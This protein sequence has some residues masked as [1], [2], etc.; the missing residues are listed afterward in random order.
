MT[1]SAPS[2]PIFSSVN[3]GDESDEDIHDFSAS[4][5]LFEDAS[6][7]PDIDT[8]DHS[9]LSPAT[10]INPLARRI[11]ME[12]DFDTD[13][14]DYEGNDLFSTRKLPLGVPLDDDTEEEEVT[15]SEDESTP[16]GRESQHSLPDPEELKLAV[17]AT[18]GGGSSFLCSYSTRKRI[19]YPALLI[20]FAF[21][22]VIFFVHAATRPTPTAEA[23]SKPIFDN[24]ED[25][26]VTNSNDTP[27]PEFPFGDM[28]MIESR[29]TYL[30]DYLIQHGITSAE[31]LRD[32]ETNANTI[33]TPQAQA[34]RWLA[35]EDNQFPD[36]PSPGQGPSTPEGYNLVSRYAMVVLYFTT[37]GKN[38]K[39]NLNFLDPNKNTCDWY[40][41]FAP[42]KGE[43]GV[44]CNPYTREIIG[45]SM[46]SNNVRGTIPSELSH[47]TSLEY[48]ESI[49]NPLS[50]SIPDGWQRLTALKTVAIAFNKLT[51]TLPSWMPQSW[52]DMEFLYLSNNALTG[53][54]PEEFSGFEKLSVLALDDNILT[55]NT[56][57]LWNA[58][59]A[60]EFAYLEDNAFTGTLPNLN[61][62]TNAALKILDVSSNR[63]NGSLPDDIFELN[64][65]EILD[66][67]GN[68]LT[69]SIPNNIPEDNFRLKFLAL[70]KNALTG[71]IPWE[72]ANLSKLSHLDLTGNQLTGWIPNELERLRDSM[73]Y[74]FLGENN[75]TEG[76]IPSFVYAMTKLRELSLKSSRRKGNIS[77]IIGALNS[78]MVLDLDDNAL[79][80]S[81]P[82]EVG[83]MTDLQFL[84]LSRN[85]LSLEVP[86]NQLAK[87]NDLR[88]LTLDNNH[89][90]GDL[91]P[92]CSLDALTSVY[93]DCGEVAC[94]EGCCKCCQDGNPCHDDLLI[95]SQDPVWE[96]GYARQ[97]FTFTAEEWNGNDDYWQ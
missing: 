12:T 44:L 69:S 90:F 61:T 82:R 30:Q 50:G 45:L 6:G 37:N 21:A 89:V 2:S 73:T 33:N 96:T 57:V 17:A 65:L 13:D 34:A 97:F 31:L 40:Q 71:S 66:L 10:A 8:I 62:E 18:T 27:E 41:V 14:S 19:L 63:L 64:R 9:T 47:V 35:Q 28:P 46:I 15:S 81:I 85:Q 11:L 4:P 36:F 94:L 54:L 70:H 59:S 56:D 20:L 29:L 76:P 83:M 5:G 74:L 86:G 25:Q 23:Q 22:I 67:H 78:L 39:D 55:G 93:V 88:F 84:L 1:D 75:Y 79:T 26:K 16:K 7:I 80:G 32:A 42:P 60:L 43:E 24:K 38:W 48:I 77:G 68:Q 49:Q 95:T 52:P 3:Y 72:I 53:T 87:L 91:N 58:M 51:G 92:I